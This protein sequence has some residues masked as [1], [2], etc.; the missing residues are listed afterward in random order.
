MKVEKTPPQVGLAG[1]GKGDY[2]RR[3]SEFDYVRANG[4]T[5]AGRLI[6]INIVS[7][8]D[9]KVRIGIIVSKGYSRKA[10]HRNRARRLIRES[11]R[12][13]RT[14]IRPPVWIIVIARRQLFSLKVQDV[15]GEFVQLLAD[16]KVSV[17]DPS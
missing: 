10:V 1:I 4:T 6:V 11:F 17:T 7:A 13:L 12:L 8:P 16:A 14:G 5:L 9:N 2:L 3:Q 15:Q